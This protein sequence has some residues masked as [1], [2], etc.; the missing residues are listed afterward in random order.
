MEGFEVLK[1]PS[2]IRQ[3]PYTT[4][5]ALNYLSR[6]IPGALGGGAQLAG[7]TD[8][9]FRGHFDVGDSSERFGWLLE[10]YRVQTDGFKDLDTGGDTGFELSDYLA[11]LRFTSDR[12]AS[13]YQALELKLSRT[14][15]H[16]DETYLGLTQD[17]F[18]RTPL[19]RYAGSQVDV[20][21][22]EHEQI[23]LSYFAQL[24]P[25]L[26]LTAVVYDNDFFRNWHKLQSVAGTGLSAVLDDPGEHPY[27]LGVLRGE[28]DSAPDDLTVRNNRRDYYGRGAQAMLGWS[29]SARHD[30]EIGLRYHEDEEDRFQEDDGYQMLDGRM[31]LTN[32]GAPGS[33]SNQISSAD[34][35]A[36]FAVDTVALGDWTLTPGLRYESID[37]GQ[38]NYGRNDPQRTGAELAVETNTIDEIIPGLGTTY[39]F[40]PSSVAFVGIHKGFA[41]PAPGSTD[42]VEAEEAV[43]YEAGYRHAAGGL[44]FEAVGFFNDY[45]N[46]LG[47][48]TLSGGGEGTGEQFN[49]G[50]ARIWGLEASVS[51]ELVAGDG[52]LVP[53]RLVYTRT[54]SEFRTSFLTSFADWAPAVERGDEIPYVP[55]DQLLLGV[56]VE[57]R[58]W[59]TWLDANYTSDVRAHAGSGAIPAAELIEARWV[60][61]LAAD[62]RPSERYRLFVQVRNLADEIYVA[63]RRPHGLRPGLPRTL[64]GGVQIDF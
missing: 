42:E 13:V 40:S 60:L 22:S 1:G 41:P 30:L 28:L 58:R 2:A 29:A 62:Y 48:D 55:R 11:K 16:D 3:G 17:D 64:I 47:T 53:L 31:L 56:G 49:G 39:R 20:F 12:D 63:A 34:A 37:L 54:E 33:Q 10:G 50:A 23:Q 15:Q 24:D 18:D 35:W 25:R 4:G 8:S 5:G 14:D 21:D 61:D 36:L 19:R 26:D 9:F 45:D 6:S 46:L 57:G 7:G 44:R 43:N 27:E 32:A 38:R 59:G 52:V 51:R